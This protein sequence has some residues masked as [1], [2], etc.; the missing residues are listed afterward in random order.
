MVAGAQSTATCNVAIDIETTS[1]TTS[2][3]PK[4]YVIMGGDIKPVNTKESKPRQMTGQPFPTLPYK[5]VETFSLPMP[6]LP[7]IEDASSPTVL[8]NGLGELM[9]SLW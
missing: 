9:L 4:A 1:G 3:V 2:T 8:R 5:G 7:V 6:M